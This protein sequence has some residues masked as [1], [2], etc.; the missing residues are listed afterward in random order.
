MNTKGLYLYC[1]ANGDKEESSE[2]KGIG[3]NLVFSISHHGLLAVVQE[4]E[5][6]PYLSE[7]QK[8]MA[9]WLLIHQNIVDHAWEKYE[10]ILPFGFDTIIKPT[11]EKSAKQN[12]T[13]WLEKEEKELKQKLN[14]L[15]NKAEYGVQIVWDPTV[16]L[17]FLKEKDAEIK[18]LEEELRSKPQGVAYLL[19][20]KLEELVKKRL[21]QAADGYFKTFY[22]SI[23]NCV[24]EIR[25]E[26]AR[27]ETP[28]LQMIANFSCLQDKG[29][30]K[31]LGAELEKIS[32]VKG[33][34]VRFTGP[35]PPYSFVST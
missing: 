15:K 11:D 32:K 18:K 25:V 33:F 3:G 27:K 2:V 17:P 14:R 31:N 4:C 30:E 22:Q 28:P 16:I 10:T 12:L 24:E 21:E 9:D 19:Q 35:W 34:N 26:K 29:K 8:V 13:E 1:V 23:R 7:D 20:K 5:A 6:K